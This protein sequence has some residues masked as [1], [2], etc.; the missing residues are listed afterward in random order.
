VEKG[1]SK[2]ETPRSVYGR[3]RSHKKMSLKSYTE[4]A[5]YSAEKPKD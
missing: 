4:Q 5:S 3:T 1:S 2:D